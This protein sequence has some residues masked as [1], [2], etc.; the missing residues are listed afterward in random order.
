[1]QCSEQ[2]GIGGELDCGLL[3]LLSA[4]RDQLGQAC[5]LE[6]A[7]R[8]ARCEGLADASQYGKPCPQRI[9][10]GGVRVVGSCIEEQVGTAMTREMLALGSARS[11]DQSSRVDASCLGLAL[12]IGL[13]PAVAF[14][15]P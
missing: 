3:I 10:G 9:A 11:K 4:V 14:Q 2:C 7:G 5:G 6:Q 15:Q 13:R 1:M 8:D 12:Q